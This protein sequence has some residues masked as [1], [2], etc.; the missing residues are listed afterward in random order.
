MRTALEGSNQKAV[1]ERKSKE[2]GVIVLLRSPMMW[3]A[4]VHGDDVTIRESTPARSTKNFKTSRFNGPRGPLEF[5]FDSVLKVDW[6]RLGKVL[7]KMM[8]MTRPARFFLRYMHR[9]VTRDCE[10]E[11]P[12]SKLHVMH[13]KKKGQ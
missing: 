6:T 1:A 10:V 11:F 7:S 8:T 2:C 12:M 5:L 3:S 13:K 9:P 4:R